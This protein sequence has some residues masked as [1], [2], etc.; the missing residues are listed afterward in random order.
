MLLHRR[1]AFPGNFDFL[2]HA[3]SPHRSKFRNS[4]MEMY[5]SVSGSRDLKTTY[6]SVCATVVNNGE[7]MLVQIFHCDL[8]NMRPA[9]IH[10]AQV[11]IHWNMTQNHF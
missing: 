4:I 2:L 6:R 3:R 1:S 9:G 7:I 8:F 11:I 10:E 5:H